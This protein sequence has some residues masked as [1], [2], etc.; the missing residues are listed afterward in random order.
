MEFKN[1]TEVPVYNEDGSIAYYQYEM[2]FE[3]E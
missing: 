3:E 2:T 1:Y